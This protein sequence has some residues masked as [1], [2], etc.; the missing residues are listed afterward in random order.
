MLEPLLIP[1]NISSWSDDNSVD[2]CGPNSSSRLVSNTRFINHSRRESIIGISIF[3]S[4]DSGP[5]QNNLVRC[6]MGAALISVIDFILRG[7]K[8][9]RTYTLLGGVCV[10]FLPMNWVV[11]RFGPKWRANRRQPSL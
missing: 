1:G 6:T 11:V 4:F 10:L 7:L 9:G 2:E 5:W 8:P 3:P